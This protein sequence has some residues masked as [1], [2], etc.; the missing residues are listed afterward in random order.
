MPDSVVHLPPSVLVALAVHCAAAVEP[1]IAALREAGRGLGV[2]IYDSLVAAQDIDRLDAR[3][4]WA[5]VGKKLK[6]LGLGSARYEQVDEGLA[7]VCLLR[8]PEAGGHGS[9]TRHSCGC[10]LGT[11]LLGGLLS[12]AADESIAVLEIECR[13]DGSEG[14]WFIVGSRGRLEAIHQKLIAG[15]PIENVLREAE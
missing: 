3:Q 9:G 2:W 15:E 8:F 10:H 13:A 11:G 6:E 12:R 1:G 4:F 14:C 5:E 7:A